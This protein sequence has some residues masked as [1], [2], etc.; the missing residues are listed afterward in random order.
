M[1]VLCSSTRRYVCSLR[2]FLFYNL[3]ILFLMAIKLRCFPF[4]ST[5]PHFFPLVTS[6]RVSVQWMQ[7]D[8]KKCGFAVVS[9]SRRIVNA[10]WRTFAN[11]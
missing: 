7:R 4:R 5:F 10:V 8:G 3:E 11:P 1:Q 2:T 6:E 9:E